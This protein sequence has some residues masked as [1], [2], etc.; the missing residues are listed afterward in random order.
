MRLR[1]LE[2]SGRL[3]IPFTTGILVGIGE[4]REER[5]ESLLAL[6][7]IAR[8]YSAIQEV[9][10]QNFRA[11]DDTAMRNDPDLDMDEYVATIATARLVFGPNMRIQAPPNLVDLAECDRLLGAGVDD[12]GGVSPLTPDH[13]NPER[14]WPQ[15]DDLAARSAANGFQLRERLTAHPQYVRAETPWIDPRVLPHVRALAAPDGLADESAFPVGLPWQEP[16]TT[17]ETSGRSDLHAAI[18][19]EGRRADVRSDFSEV[20]GDW[21][22]IAARVP[23]YAAATVAAAGAKIPA[24]VL[25]ALKRAEIDPAGLS[26]DEALLLMTAEGDALEAVCAIADGLRHDVV[27]DNV[28]YVVNRNVNFTN[29]CYT[30]CRFCAFAQRAQ[31]ADAYTLSMDEIE[32]RVAEAWNDGATEICMQGG[33]DPALPATAYFDLARAVKR[34]AA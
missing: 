10:V 33:I 27:G 30:G 26:D 8:E 29:V 32:Q 17:W 22:E 3:G 15:I 16:E 13:V 7:K 23:T 14:P 18:D 24:D 21:T 1:V 20:Y 19:T 12:W 5:A 9:I 2:D 25:A 31:D 28:T 11:K 34:A 4:T 6:R